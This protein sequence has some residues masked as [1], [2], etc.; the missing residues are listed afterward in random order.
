F[1]R[2]SQSH[3]VRIGAPRRQP[4][5]ARSEGPR[6]VGVKLEMSAKCARSLRVPPAAIQKH[7]SSVVRR[8]TGVDACQSVHIGELLVHPRPAAASGWRFWMPQEKCV[9]HAPFGEGW[10]EGMGFTEPC[11][12]PPAHTK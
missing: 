6:S 9:V 7:A 1:Q 8:I 10:F 4:K 2:V 12:E 11:Q 3:R 5:V